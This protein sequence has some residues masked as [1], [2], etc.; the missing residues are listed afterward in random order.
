MGIATI[1]ISMVID[2][3]SVEQSLCGHQI[4]MQ[5]G[6]TM[7]TVTIVTTIQ[8]KIVIIVKN[9]VTYPRTVLEHISRETIKDG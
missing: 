7:H 3:L 8:D 9:M 2:P 4:S 6:T 5:E 1:A